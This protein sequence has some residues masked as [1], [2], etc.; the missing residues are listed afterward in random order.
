MG[1]LGRAA[2]CN[3]FLFHTRNVFTNLNMSCVG[4]H[5]RNYSLFSQ[6]EAE[7]LWRK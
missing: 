1:K 7:S 3:C 2:V 5:P 4:E 6:V